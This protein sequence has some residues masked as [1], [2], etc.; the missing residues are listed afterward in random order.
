MSPFSL[1]PFSF[2]LTNTVFG[3][4]VPRASSPLINPLPNPE[5]NFLHSHL[6]YIPTSTPSINFF[7]FLNFLNFHLICF[8]YLSLFIFPPHEL[9][10]FGG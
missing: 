6:I 9:R 5:L 1:S 7:T 4:G 10:R 8:L 3:P 2:S